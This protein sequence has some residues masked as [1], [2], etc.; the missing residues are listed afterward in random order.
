MKNDITVVKFGSEI[1]CSKGGV[2]QAT[3]N[4]YVDGLMQTYDYRGLVV[5]TSGAVKTGKELIQKKGLRA[6]S[7]S[8]ATLAQIGCASV[9]RAWERAFER[10]NVMAGGL[11]ATH[12]DIL[13][14]ANGSRFVKS[15]EAAIS[16]GIVSVVNENDA[17]SEEELIQFVW[18]GDNDGLASLIAQKLMAR[19]LVIFTELGGI[20]DA[21]GQLVDV[22]SKDNCVTIETELNRRSR[23]IGTS[24]SSGRGGILTKFKAA[25]DAA[26]VGIDVCIAAINTDMTGEKITWF[27]W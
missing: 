1:V 4:Q 7:C 23:E 27:V 13:G 18:G 12:S 11:L 10:H 6:D 2:N 15:L 14:G 25:Q 19:R 5:V 8:T 26:K 3:I 9:M 24:K 16:G 17:V 21:R 22:V 20:L